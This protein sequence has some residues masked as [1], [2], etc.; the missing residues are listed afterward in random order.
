ML[1]EAWPGAIGCIHQDVSQELER[2]N[3]T[4]DRLEEELATMKKDGD[5]LFMRY[6]KECDHCRKVEDDVAHYRARLRLCED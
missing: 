1:E 6:E 4:I 3:Q 2:A 5:N